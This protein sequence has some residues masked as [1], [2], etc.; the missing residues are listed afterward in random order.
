M[1]AALPGVAHLEQDDERACRIHSAF[2]AHS[3]RLQLCCM[4]LHGV[5][6]EDSIVGPAG[7]RA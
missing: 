5:D 1:R 3:Q 2:T 7:V 6:Q 4:A